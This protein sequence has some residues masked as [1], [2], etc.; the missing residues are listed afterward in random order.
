MNN[1][2]LLTSLSKLGFPMFEP[3]E[4]PDVNE[5]L[6]EVVK[7]HDTRLW[8]GFPVLLA[9]AAESYLFT[10]EQVRQQLA[11]KEQKDHFHRLMLLSGSLFS[12]YH[13]S[14]SWWNKLKK[15]LSKKDKALVKKWRNYLVHNQT[16]K[17]NDAELDPERLKGMFELYFEKKAEKDRRRK[18]KFV[19]FSLENALS[20]VFS[21]KQKELFK[22]KLE[23]LPLNKTEQEYYSRTVKKKVVALANAEL[24][25]LARKLLEQ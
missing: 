13:L 8:E 16:L 24:H 20:Q 2:K 15:N 22:K 14:F 1:R 10:P 18:E 4:E 7:S 17:F 21:P 5:T 9:N 12:L 25:S 19:E 3:S 23:G 6:A 11:G